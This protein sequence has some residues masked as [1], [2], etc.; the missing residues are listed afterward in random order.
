MIILF[1]VFYLLVALGFTLLAMEKKE[2][3]GF[4]VFCGLIWPYFLG[5]YLQDKT[6][7]L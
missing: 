1:V 5:G 7:D 6:K 2:G 3:V 4:A